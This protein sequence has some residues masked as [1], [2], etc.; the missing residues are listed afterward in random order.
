MAVWARFRGR[1]CSKLAELLEYS[2]LVTMNSFKALSSIALVLSLA[3][4]G[5]G[6]PESASEPAEESAMPEASAPVAE[7]TG[8]TRRPFEPMLEGEWIGNA[9]PCDVGR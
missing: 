3:A 4:C 1:L 5:G 8:I 2:R 6:Q 9:L 7:A